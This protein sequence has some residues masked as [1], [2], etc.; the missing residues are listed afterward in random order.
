V[1]PRTEVALSNVLKRIERPHAKGGVACTRIPRFNFFWYQDHFDF[2]P[3][4]YK[5]KYSRLSSQDKLGHDNIH[6]FVESLHPVGVI[7]EDDNC[8]LDSLV[9]PI[10][11]PQVID[12]QNL[13]FSLSP[14]K[15]LGS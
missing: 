8:K 4:L 5:C 13:V 15:L 6:R 10:T 1:R 14:T 7:D 12:T 9:N 11:I 3:K 2:E